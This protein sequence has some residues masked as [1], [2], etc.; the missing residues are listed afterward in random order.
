MS[1]VC[2]A[3]ANGTSDIGIGVSGVCV[4]QCSYGSSIGIEKEVAILQPP[5]T[6]GQSKKLHEWMPLSELA[7]LATIALVELHPEQQGN[8][9]SRIDVRPSKGIVKVLFD[10]S[11]WEVQLDAKSG[12]VL[13]VARRHSD[14]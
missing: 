2:V 9:I 12:E 10:K 5:T 7:Q 1:A 11:H 4:C 14:W 6:K 3:F 8:T 13:S